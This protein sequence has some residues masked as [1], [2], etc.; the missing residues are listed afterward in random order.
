MFGSLVLGRQ[1]G[2]DLEAPLTS[3]N[4]QRLRELFPPSPRHSFPLE[5]AVKQKTQ[6]SAA[7]TQLMAC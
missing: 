7:E 1:E 2:A 5:K 3:K 6:T 4:K